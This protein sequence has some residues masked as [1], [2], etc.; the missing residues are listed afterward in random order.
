MTFIGNI[1]TKNATI[2]VSII[3]VV[4]LLFLEIGVDVSSID[5]RPSE[6]RSFLN[7]TVSASK[8]SV[9]FSC[10]IIVT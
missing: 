1:H 9:V 10:L 2:T 8:Q 3:N 6:F 5:N 4:F 7:L